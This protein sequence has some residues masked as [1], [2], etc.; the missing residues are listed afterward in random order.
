MSTLWRKAARDMGRE[1][2]RTTLVVLAIALGLA[3]FTTVL[4]SYAILTRELARGYRATNPADFTLRVAR[5]DDELLAAV[6]ADPAVREVEPRRTLAARIRAGP[7]EWRGLTLFAVP[8]FNAVRVSRFEPEQGAWPPAAGEILIERDALQVVRARIGDSLTVR[9]RSGEHSLRLSGSVHDAGQAQARMENAVY[10]YVALETLA[11]LGEEPFLDQ[12]E[13]TVAENGVAEDELDEAHV[14]RVAEGLAARISAHGGEVLAT[15]VPPPGQ[16]PHAAIMGLLLLAMAAFGAL[17]LAFSGILVV[18]LMSAW[19]AAQVRQ[20]GVMKALGGTRARI[21]RLYLGQAA[22]LGVAAIVLALPFGLWG[23]RVLS[24]AQAVFLNFDLESFAVPA[25]VFAL[26]AVAGLLV[27]LLAA[28]FPVWRGCGVSV[29]A[30]LGDHGV[31]GTVFGQSALDRRLTGIGG[32]T[33]PLAYALRNGFRRRTR[34]VLTLVTLA[35]GG[36]FFLTALNVRAALIHTLDRLFETKRSDLSVTLA[37]LTPFE[38]VERAV[39]R[40]PGILRW[41]GW[42]ASTAT[43][44]RAE[45]PRASELTAGRG[46]APHAAGPAAGHAGGVGAAASFPVVALPPESAFVARNIVEGRDLERGETDA[47]VANSALAEALPEMRVG[48]SVTLAMG[49]AELTWRVVG[50]ARE[51]FSP[52]LAYVPRQLFDELGGHAGM[53]NTLRLV[54]ES[55]APAAIATVRE[56]FER[57]LEREGVR[58]LSS[59]SKAEGRYGFDQHMRMLYVFLL[60]V[61]GLLACVGALGLM[62]SLS[63]NVSERKA[64]LGVLRALGATPRT[65][66]ALVVTEGVMIACLGWIAAALLAWPL[67]TVLGDTLVQLMMRSTLDSSFELPA[68]WIW[69]GLSLALGALASFLPAWHASRCSVREALARE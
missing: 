23:S 13:V 5:V 12:L 42:I 20:I 43:P 61:A 40:T 1:R 54:L 48:N 34:L 29:R 24:R 6:G 11:Q 62:T 25:W 32:M 56:A 67:G 2:A 27:P 8:D 39:A 7:V 59:S 19:M 60:V 57:E 47:L 28:A 15:D 37:A 22:G 63:L 14:R 53:S 69:L 41:E 17:L 66:A 35:A 30:A 64:E 52:P 38:P 46:H 50:I 65:V 4:A 16:H 10:G 44:A 58:A 3:G 49:P 68:L 26:V 36:A 45:E 21:G 55:T 31:P 33:R 18:N 9:T 51:P